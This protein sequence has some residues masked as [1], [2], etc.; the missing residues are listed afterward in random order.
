MASSLDRLS[1][2]SYC[3]RER[4][5]LILR[6]FTSTESFSHH[7]LHKPKYFRVLLNTLSTHRQKQHKDGR[8]KEKEKKRDDCRN[9]RQAFEITDWCC[10]TWHLLS[11][12]LLDTWHRLKSNPRL[13]LRS[14]LLLCQEILCRDSES[15]LQPGEYRTLAQGLTPWRSST[16]PQRPWQV[17]TTWVNTLW[18]TPLKLL[19]PGG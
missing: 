12:A 4:Q 16:N 11:D 8:R 15:V 6:L 10:F 19:S 5:Q 7:D 3:S 9:W 1:I 2:T 13:Y 14:T 18:R 17:E